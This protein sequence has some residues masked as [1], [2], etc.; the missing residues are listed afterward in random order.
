M[1][2][3]QEAPGATTQRVLAAARRLHSPGSG[4]MGEGF[5]FLVT[6]GVAVV[7]NV[8]LTNVLAYVVGLPFEL[9]F[10]IGLGTAV[11]TQFALFRLW[12]WRGK[13]FALRLHHQAGRFVLAVALVYG[14]TAAAT[15]LLPS[16]LGVPTEVVYLACVAAS[17]GVSFLISRHGIFHPEEDAENPVSPAPVGVDLPS[18]N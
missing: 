14:L 16:A 8:A 1:G 11:T 3:L 10:A 9:A 12:V 2:S 7:I 6:G 18:H 13:E 4:L 15:S 17:P 5:R